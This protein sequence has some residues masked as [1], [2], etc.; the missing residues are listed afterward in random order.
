MP[1]EIELTILIIH[2]I[3]G[4]TL[5]P[6]NFNHVIFKENFYTSRAVFS[7]KIEEYI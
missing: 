3:S 5:S 2:I 6:V 1:K 7:V 4:I